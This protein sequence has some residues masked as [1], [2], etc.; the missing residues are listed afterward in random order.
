MMNN[1]LCSR[2]IR[3]SLSI[4]ILVLWVVMPCS[5]VGSYKYCWET[6]LL[7]TQG[8]VVRQQSTGVTIFRLKSL[9][10]CIVWQQYTGG[11]PRQQPAQ[12]KSR[13]GNRRLEQFLYVVQFH[14]NMF[15]LKH[16][17]RAVI[18]QADSAPNYSCYVRHSFLPKGQIVTTFDKPNPQ[19]VVITLNGHEVTTHWKEVQTAVQ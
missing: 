2:N 8:D 17:D 14:C 16:K 4:K 9:N 5:L 12:L 19:N 11:L 6:C 3:W 13:N 18:N 10:S 7:Y 1:K 15:Q